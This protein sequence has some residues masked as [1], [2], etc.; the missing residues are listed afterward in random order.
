MSVETD[1]ALWKQL[2]EWAW[3]GVM[4]MLG[5]A[6]RQLNGRI[7]SIGDKAD[8][9]VAKE[10]FRAYQ[11]R[12]DVSRKELREAIIDLYGKTDESSKLL[13]KIAGKLGV[14]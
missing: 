10:D 6:W 12:A 14:D 5:V 7:D 9:A 2:L 1:V 4:A 8:Q 3:A 13:S 11:E